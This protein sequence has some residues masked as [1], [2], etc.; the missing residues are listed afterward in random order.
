MKY[1]FYH[2][3]GASGKVPAAIHVTPE[4]VDGGGIAKLRDGDIVRLDAEQGS[5][6]ALVDPDEWARRSA[7][8]LEPPTEQF[9]MGTELFANFRA[10]VSGAD[11]GASVL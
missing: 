10:L 4:A 8:Q 9:G 3:S 6:E 1:C 11:T 7:E 5:L 2:P